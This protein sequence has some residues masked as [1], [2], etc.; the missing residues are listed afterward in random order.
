MYLIDKPIVVTTIS[1]FFFIL[2]AVC[3]SDGAKLVE[4]ES[5]EEQAFVELHLDPSIIAVIP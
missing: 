5:V 4:I 2:K 1:L 3:S